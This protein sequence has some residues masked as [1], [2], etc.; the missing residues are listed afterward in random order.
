MA[1]SPD[2]PQLPPEMIAALAKEDQSPQIIGVVAAFTAIAFVCVVLRFFVRITMVRIVGMEDYFMAISMLSSIF[3]SVCL[4]QGARLGNGRHMINVPMT[5]GKRI[6]LYLFFGILTYHISLTATKLS[7]LLQ[8]RRIF[9]LKNSRIVI[10]I[11]MGICTACGLTAIVSAIFTCVPVDAYWNFTKRPFSKCVNQDAMYHAN[12]GINM[13][14]D[15]LVA[16]LPIR[17]LWTLRIPLRQK[18][19]VVILLTLGWF[20]VIISVLRLVFLVK[21]AQHPEDTTWY[22]GPV[23]LWSA[24]EI[25]LAIVCATTPA[26]KPLIVKVLPNFGTRFGTIQ[27]NDVSGQIPTITTH[28]QRNNANFVRLKGM[29]SHSSM[30]DAVHLKSGA[31]TVLEQSHGHDEWKEIRVTRDVE[32]GSINDDGISDESPRSYIQYPPPAWPLQ[33]SR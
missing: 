29:P 5:N 1:T 25:N 2:L 12:A 24:L 19:A 10:Y 18:I 31:G 9:T 4:I 30:G 11:A 16:V 6:F 14:T 33:S 15:L 23:A 21:V 26:L 32:Q 20:V 27:P 7:I 8:Y 13:F 17:N 22:G 28:S 3:T